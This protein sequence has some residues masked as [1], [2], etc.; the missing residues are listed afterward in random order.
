MSGWDRL[1]SSD[2]DEADSQRS[3][4]HG[5]P[6]QQHIATVDANIDELHAELNA[7]KQELRIAKEELQK[8]DAQKI[9][10][11]YDR[12]VLGK[13]IKQIRHVREQ[14]FNIRQELTAE[15]DKFNLFVGELE[16]YLVESTSSSLEAIVFLEGLLGT[17]DDGRA[18]IIRHLQT[19]V[20][21]QTAIL[22]ALE[23]RI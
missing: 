8:L 4:P 15:K 9:R 18:D 14:S 23:K 11:E 17:Q 21:N 5:Q 7:V 12:S 3:T 1:S 13:E 10:C 22:E 6:A 16:K 2:E 19:Q 20:S